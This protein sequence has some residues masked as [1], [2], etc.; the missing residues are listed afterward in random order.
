MKQT[1]NFSTLLHPSVKHL[2]YLGAM[3]TM[4]CTKHLRCRYRSELPI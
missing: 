2:S 4:L 1:G 3:F